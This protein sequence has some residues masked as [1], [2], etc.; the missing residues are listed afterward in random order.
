VTEIVVSARRLGKAYVRYARE[1]QRFA[2]WIGLGTGARQER[3]WALREVDLDI[4]RGEAFGF[5]GRNGAGKSTLLKLVAGVLRPSEGT[6]DVRGRVAA[7][8]E[9]GT[10]FSPE[11]TCRQNARVVANL[12]GI[13]SDRI[14]SALP[15]IAEFADIGEYFER[16]LRECSSGMQMRVAFAVATAFEPE[17]LIIDEALAVGDASFQAKCFERIE[18]FRARGCTL[19]FVSHA[20]EAVAKHCDRALF[21]D[22]GRIGMSG[23]PRPVV[24]AYLEHMFASSTA[25]STARSTAGVTAGSS[26]QATAHASTSSG[27][28][29]AARLDADATDRFRQ[30]PGYRKDEQ[31]WGSGAARILDFSLAVDASEYPPALPAGSIVTLAFKVEFVEDVAQPVFG[32]LLKTHD[33]VFLFGSNSDL[34]GDPSAARGARAG[35]VRVGEFRFRCALNAGAYLLSVGISDGGPDGAMTP[36]D[37]RYDSILVT[38]EHARPFWG[39]ADL[40]SRFALQEPGS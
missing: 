22:G 2:D 31:R 30:R 5:L 16:P 20:V 29:R 1:W 28:A 23:E 17:I 10:G 32:M 21:L 38:V 4:R 40:D 37:R 11:L 18:G 27:S 6:I 33:G 26:V 35:E 8:L 12:H 34:C 19:L 9:L 13:E 7:I 14:E 24:N 25:R 3:H 15:G 39:I 36:L